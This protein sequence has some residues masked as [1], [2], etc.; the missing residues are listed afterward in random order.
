MLCSSS[1]PGTS[2][3]SSTRRNIFV[4]LVYNQLIVALKKDYRSVITRRDEHA[5]KKDGNRTIANI[6]MSEPDSPTKVLSE[7]SSLTTTGQPLV[8]STRL[9]TVRVTSRSVMEISVNDLKR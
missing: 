3:A 1:F 9:T 6:V 4:S 5:K 8:F 7:A 2:G